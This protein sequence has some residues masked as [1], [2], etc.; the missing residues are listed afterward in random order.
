MAT[1]AGRG[2]GSAGHAADDDDRFWF[3]FHED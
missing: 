1:R 3:G 2:G